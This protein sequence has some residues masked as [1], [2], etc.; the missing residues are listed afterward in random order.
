MRTG[1]EL[2][3]FVH[4]IIPQFPSQCTLLTVVVLQDLASSDIEFFHIVSIELIPTS[5]KD[6]LEPGNEYD[7]KFGCV[8]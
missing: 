1:Q 6:M 5:F 2:I 4:C 7:R 3:L 8:M